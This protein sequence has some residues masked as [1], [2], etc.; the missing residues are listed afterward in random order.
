MRM[1]AKKDTTAISM[2]DATIL[3]AAIPAHA[4]MALLVRI[5]NFYHLYFIRFT[6]FR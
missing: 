4:E 3:S 5:G 1:N 6:N 2:H